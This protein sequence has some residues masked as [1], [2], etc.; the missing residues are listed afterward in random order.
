M[1]TK[2]RRYHYTTEVTVAQAVASATLRRQSVTGREPSTC[3]LR[4]AHA[5]ILPRRLRFPVPSL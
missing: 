1:I 3:R 4:V 2:S 5:T